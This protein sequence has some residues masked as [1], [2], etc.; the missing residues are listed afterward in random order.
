MTIQSVPPNTM[1]AEGKSKYAAIDVAEAAD[2][3]ISPRADAMPMI[4]VGSM[5]NWL[6]SFREAVKQQQIL[7]QARTP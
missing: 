4:V 2:Q 7:G 5:V 6:P 1:A 3:R